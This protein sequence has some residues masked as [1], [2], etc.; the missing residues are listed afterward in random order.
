[1]KVYTKTG[2]SGTTS[3]IGGQRVLKCDPRVEGYGKADE[4]SAFLALLADMMR[5]NGKFSDVCTDTCTGAGIGIG[6]VDWFDDIQKDLFTVEAM[7]AVGGADGESGGRLEGKVADLPD[8][9]VAKLE[10]RIDALSEGL[11]PVKGFVIPG[12]HPIVSMCHVCRTVCREAERLAVGLQMNYGLPEVATRYLNR[13][14]D[15]LYVVG[16]KAVVI[17]SIKER[18]WLP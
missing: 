12:G 2:D 6:I 5:E 14:S 8:S 11:P 13:L 4:L 10:N 7:M 9:A 3:L 15:F 17:L 1:M 18:Y 16:R